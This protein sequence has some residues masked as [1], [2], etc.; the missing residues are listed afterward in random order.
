MSFDIMIRSC[1]FFVP[2][3]SIP[4]GNRKRFSYQGTKNF[5]PNVIS[6][7]LF[8]GSHFYL[9]AVNT[10]FGRALEFLGA[11]QKLQKKKHYWLSRVCPSA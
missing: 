1:C 6:P 10:L 2:E 11:F 5:S 8:D 9:T 4:I 3:M 7:E